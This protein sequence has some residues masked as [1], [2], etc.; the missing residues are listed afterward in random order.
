MGD[1]RLAVGHFQFARIDMNAHTV[2]F[3]DIDI[4]KVGLQLHIATG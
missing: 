2:T 1:F 3:P 4:I